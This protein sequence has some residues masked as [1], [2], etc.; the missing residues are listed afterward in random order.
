MTHTLEGGFI[1]CHGE[2]VKNKDIKTFETTNK[3]RTDQRSKHLA[4]P[5]LFFRCAQVGYQKGAGKGKV[6]GLL[7]HNISEQLSKPVRSFV[8]PTKDQGSPAW[9]NFFTLLL[10]KLNSD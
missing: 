5:K 9:G 1:A 4:H 7:Q 10:Q 8:V 2:E 3:L 6:S